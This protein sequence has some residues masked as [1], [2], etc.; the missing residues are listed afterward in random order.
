MISE[1]EAIDALP[2]QGFVRNYVEYAAQC[3][4]AN[5][6]YHIAG[7]LSCLTQCV[8][9]EY[10]VPYASPIHGNLYS[11]IVGGSSK[12]R[13]TA[14]INIAQ[15]ICREAIIDSIGE[16]PG[17]QE[18]LYE[19]LRG[20]NRQLIVYGEWGEFL[21]KAE[22]GYLM[23]MKTAY[24]SL[25]DCLDE[26]TEILT[27]SG[28]KR[29]GE[30]G[31]GDTCYSMNPATGLLEV[32]PIL[33][34]GERPVREGERMFVL[35]GQRTDIR[36][37]E[38]HRFILR[39]RFSQ[40]LHWFTGAEWANR[41]DATTFRMPVGSVGATPLWTSI[42]LGTP[43]LVSGTAGEIVWCVSN[44]NETLVTRRNGKV[45]IIGN[46]VPI[47]RALAKTKRGNIQN[48]RLSLLTAVAT[49]LLERHTEMADWTGG[50]LARFLTIYGEPE[51]EFPTPPVD[52]MAK[53]RNIVQWLAG[54]S[55]PPPNMGA[56]LWLDKPAEKMW[57][58]WYESLR[59]LREGA[60]RRASAACS[61]SSA[62]AAKVAILL[63]WDIGQARSGGDWNV[64]I[65]VL[66]PALK[67]TNLHIGSVLELG[68]RVTGTKDMRD[69]ASVLR[70]I[71]DVPTP[72]GVVLRESEMLKRRANEILESLQEERAIVK[73]QVNDVI[74]YV[75]TPDAQAMLASFVPQYQAA[76][77][78]QA[79]GGNL[80]ALPPPKPIVPIAPLV[81]PTDALNELDPE[82]NFD[83]YWSSYEG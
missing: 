61:R 15:R 21:A 44:R 28:W 9:P 7:A 30:V 70:A 24:T 25:W 20:Q 76:K 18:G 1:Q 40:G 56:C 81:P 55:A 50:F 67:I 79:A 39:D 32:T 34:Y 35:K 49:D 6:A 29:R 4:D 5:L 14:S 53:R 31:P 43:T 82:E 72:V 22:E 83:T 69:R 38:G 36:T 23:S 75:K 71:S 68:E 57:L 45:A 59:P 48:P 41:P 74:C 65:D 27:P 42:D 80:V 62:I 77:A 10:A 19:S 2:S 63:A 12:S 54:L 64:G 13:K 73:V 16:M 26:E 51:R 33:D 11:M 46:C 8:P 60:N 52:N 37:T 17:S 78:S 66:E 58:D 47:G 3:T